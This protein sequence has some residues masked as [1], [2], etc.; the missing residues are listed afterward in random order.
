MIWDSAALHT[1]QTMWPT[2]TAV[3][4]AKVL[5]TTKGS[6]I[7]MAHRKGY[8]KT[9]FK[10][11]ADLGVGECRWNLSIDGKDRDAPHRDE[12]CGKPTFDGRSYCKEHLERSFMKTSLNR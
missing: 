11:F 9:A 10:R 1:L 12:W 5:G 2:H 4:I 6:V 8:S 3:Q 7:G